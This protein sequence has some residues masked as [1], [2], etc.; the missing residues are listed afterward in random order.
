MSR[1]RFAFISESNTVVQIIAGTLTDSQADD[2]VR[3]YRE[4]FG[5]NAWVKVADESTPIWIGGTYD[6]TV[7]FAPPPDPIIEQPTEGTTDGIPV[8]E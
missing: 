5:A 1:S 7:G 2:F 3:H 8:L 6:S 4:Q